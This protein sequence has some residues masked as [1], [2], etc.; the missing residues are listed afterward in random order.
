MFMNMEIMFHILIEE[1]VRKLKT[2][3]LWLIQYFEYLHG[4]LYTDGDCHV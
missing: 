2:K 4:I 1:N 3:I